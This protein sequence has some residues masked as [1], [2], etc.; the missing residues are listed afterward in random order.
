M[1]AV[2]IECLKSGKVEVETCGELCIVKIGPNT[3]R[4]KLKRVLRRFSQDYVFCPNV[5]VQGFTPF[6]TK[7]YK[8]DVLFYQFC[9]FLSVRRCTDM[10]VGI[11]DKKG[12]YKTALINIVALCKE[13][14]LVTDIDYDDVLFK[15]KIA[16]GATPYITPNKKE[17]MDCD[18]VFCAD[19]LAGFTGGLFGNGGQTVD[20][21]KIRLPKV[22]EHAV[23]LGVDVLDIAAILSV[24]CDEFKPC[25]LIKG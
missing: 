19:G 4:G 9:E 12:R 24:D 7:Q 13:V 20:C 15:C 14:V 11:Y 17:L 16:T 25:N 2:V 3:R 6:S 5:H 18:V 22:Y 8:E 1:F 10:T 23:S 21:K